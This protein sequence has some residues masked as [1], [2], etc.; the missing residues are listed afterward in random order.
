MKIN[1][2]PSVQATRIVDAVQ[3]SGLSLSVSADGAIALEIKFPGMKSVAFSME[4]LE[5]LASLVAE[6]IPSGSDVVAVARR[7]RQVSAD[8]A[9]AFRFSDEARSRSLEVPADQRSE[10]ADMLRG[11]AADRERYEA[12]V[13]EALASE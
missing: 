2:S 3:E 11:L 13:R 4:A 12:L 10:V 7:S 9:I 6:P 1:L 5:D 8:G